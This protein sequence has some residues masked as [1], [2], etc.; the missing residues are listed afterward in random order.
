MTVQ[1]VFKDLENQIGSMQFSN[2][3]ITIAQRP[4]MQYCLFNI[5]C[6]IDFTGTCLNLCPSVIS[7][8]MTLKSQLSQLW[9]V[10]NR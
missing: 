6:Q 8:I 1:R 9:T 7:G 2:L 5:R 3:L 4:T 10:L